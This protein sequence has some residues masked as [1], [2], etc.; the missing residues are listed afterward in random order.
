MTS[1]PYLR[2]V[3]TPPSPPSA[4]PG[5]TLSGEMAVGPL[6]A[7]VIVVGAGPS[8]AAAALAA[9]RAGASVL[10]L[11]RVPPP[12]YKRCGGGLV[13]YSCALAPGSASVAVSEVLL[14]FDGGR[15]R[16][17][18]TR[19]GPPLLHLSNRDGFDAAQVARAEAAGVRL[20]AERTVTG[21]V[22]HP[23]GVTVLTRSGPLRAAVVVGADGATGRSA[24]HVG[25][26]YS[27]VDLGLEAEVP[28]DAAVA[29][30][31]AGSVLLDWGPVPGSYGWVFPKG[32]VLTVGV[33]GDRA[34]SAA[35]REYFAALLARFSLSV[36]G[37]EHSGGHLTRVRAAGSPLQRGRVIV[38]GDAAGLLEPFT[39]EGISYALRSGRLAGLAAARAAALGSPVPLEG[40]PAA[41]Q[42][43]FGAEMD[44]GSAALAAFTRHPALLHEALAS[45]PGFALFSR[46]VAGRSTFSRQLRRPGVSAVLRLAGAR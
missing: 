28:V 4:A 22:Q 44:A 18:G 12:R 3:R 24:A 5:P 36:D 46:H 23:D 34:S 39:R 33:I 7:D 43:T 13:G 45:P 35:L 40:Y 27:Q 9:R 31:W 10:L 38:A 42:A 32:R 15:L 16:R 6:D 26:R 29:A 20:D 37:A 14:T 1:D 17:R 2:G 8:G 30:R 25:V 41:V 11:D 21:F 19:S